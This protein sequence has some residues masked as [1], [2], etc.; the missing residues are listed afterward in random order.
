MEQGHLMTNGIN[1]WCC[2]TGSIFCHMWH[3][4]QK[5]STWCCESN[6]KQMLRSLWQSISLWEICTASVFPSWCK[7]K[8]INVLFKVCCAF[9]VELHYKKL[10]IIK[11]LVPT[12]LTVNCSVGMVIWWRPTVRTPGVTVQYPVFITCETPGKRSL[13]YG[14][15]AMKSKF[16]DACYRRSIYEQFV[17]S[18]YRLHR[19]FWQAPVMF[20]SI[21]RH[22]LP[23]PSFLE[24][25][26]LNQF[27]AVGTPFVG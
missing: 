27:W 15:K 1:S 2:C 7:I 9:E 21:C 11:L 24:A 17:Y 8:R 5:K 14:V 18:L 13:L 25:N 10:N 26:F 6:E 20:D 4:S 3:S 23:I 19:T 16:L 22:S 12:V